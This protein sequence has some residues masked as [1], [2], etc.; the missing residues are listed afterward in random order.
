MQAW[1]SK[2]ITFFSLVPVAF[3]AIFILY[4]V[5]KSMNS[6]ADAK[7]TQAELRLA[8][9]SYELLTEVQKERGMS[10]GFIGSDGADFKDALLVQ[11]EKVDFSIN[12]LT[13]A[14]AGEKVYFADDALFQPLNSLINKLKRSR[15][16]VD[17]LSTSVPQTVEYYTQI[18]GILINFK[19]SLVKYVN[20]ANA[21]Q[22]FL[23][24][25]K[26]AELQE[27]SG[28]ERAMLSNYFA[29]GDLNA[30][31]LSAHKSNL[32]SQQTLLKNLNTLSTPEFQ[33]AIT[34][35]TNSNA[36]QSVE[37]FRSQI[38]NYA[39]QQLSA[40]S[41]D[42][43]A[44][45]TA[46]INEIGNL[47]ED[48]FLQIAQSN[49][50]ELVD[51]TSYMI[52]NSI[53][54]AISI[55]LTAVIY[56]VLKQRQAQSSELKHKLNMLATDRDLTQ[57]I[58]KYSNDDLGVVATKVNE[59][60][61][62]IKTDLLEFQTSAN[63][64]TFATNQVAESS[65]LTRENINS[66][67]SNL[68]Q[69]LTSAELLSAGINADIES[70]SKIAEYTKLSSAAVKDG[71]KLVSKAVADIHETAHEVNKVGESIDLLNTKVGDILK[72]VDVIRS[73]AEQTNLLALN[74]AIEAARAGEQGRGFAVVADE[75]RAL[76]KRVQDSTV[77]I[78]SV[79]DELRDSSDQAFNTI[80]KGAERAN[81]TVSMADSIR[82]AL[83]Q[84]AEN[85]RELEDFSAAVE[86]SAQQ[87]SFSLNGMT[88]GIR[89]IDAMS[90]KNAEG[91]EKV[92]V[93]SNQL[94]FTANS[95]LDNIS[96]YTT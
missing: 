43:F 20:D 55:V 45:S 42:W 4:A 87:Q 80:A 54:M 33:S 28:L 38:R 18:T 17:S 83:Q 70:I 91:A 1:L 72:M 90:E 65:E 59:L 86:Q 40:Q 92:A 67:H 66:Q 74:A 41:A 37:P 79:V 96:K 62:Q 58:D 95:M 52:F 15:T 3:L 94:A 93:A 69:S 47:V 64:I 75:V 22:G 26:L 50:N 9:L 2:R 44:Q 68:T 76:A 30:N 23:L 51:S 78:S 82:D 60:V 24:L 89:E 10:A 35:F 21:K 27:L 13:K 81:N 84:I 77:E 39:T 6:L 85:M 5:V 88:S 12:A 36:V 48:L 32:V 14:E 34:A 7:L 49:E 46:R 63:E 16:E 31:Q 57:V 29:L 19:A 11:R 8:I 53:L 56:I 61:D 73:V 71:E 25:F